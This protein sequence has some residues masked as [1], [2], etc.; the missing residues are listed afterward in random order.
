MIS[1]NNDNVTEHFG[2]GRYAMIK[3]KAHLLPP[4][5]KVKQ[6]SKKPLTVDIIWGTGI[7]GYLN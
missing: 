7:D 4:P 3:R 6:G 1:T 2:N 5:D